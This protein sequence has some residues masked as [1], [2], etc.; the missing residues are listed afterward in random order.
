MTWIKAIQVHFEI[1]HYKAQQKEMGQRLSEIHKP[2]SRPKA[3]LDYS[4]RQP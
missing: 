4:F 1:I 3:Q 2:T